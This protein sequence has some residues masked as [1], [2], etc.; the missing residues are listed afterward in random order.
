MSQ[1][2]FVDIIHTMA[3]TAGADESTGTVDFWPNGGV[4]QPGCFISAADACSHTRSWQYF[5]ESISKLEDKFLAVR[6]HSYK[7]FLTSRCDGKLS[8]NNMGIDVDMKSSGNYY[9]QTNPKIPFSRGLF[10]TQYSV[11]TYDRDREK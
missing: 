1:F 2:Q 11:A 10:G 4:K 8:L 9:L 6:C 7:E 3:G 5:A